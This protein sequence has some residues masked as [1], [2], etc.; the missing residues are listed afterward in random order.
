[1][2]NNLGDDERWGQ[3]VCVI[4]E[5][6]LGYSIERTELQDQIHGSLSGDKIPPD[7]RLFGHSE[8]RLSGKRDYR[9]ALNTAS[10]RLGSP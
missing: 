10:G 6:K 7:P 2:A 4:V 3:Q 1:M 8:R 9:Q 5:T